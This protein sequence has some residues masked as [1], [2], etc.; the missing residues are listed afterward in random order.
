MV[1]I[2][3]NFGSLASS[4]LPPNLMSAT[5]RTAS[6][7]TMGCTAPRMP[8][9]PLFIMGSS[10]QS[11]LGGPM[12][13]APLSARRLIIPSG[14]NTQLIIPSGRNTQQACQIHLIGIASARIKIRMVN[15]AYSLGRQRLMGARAARRSGTDR[16]TGPECRS[17]TSS[18]NRL[19]PILI[20][21]TPKP[22][23][24]SKCPTQICFSSFLR[25]PN[26]RKRLG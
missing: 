12:P 11:T 8:M 17:E 6:A 26:W 5:Q 15:F 24:S 18:K 25:K 13:I 19:Q 16:R 2:Y 14:R 9:M 7:S 4:W 10:C 1:L 23:G 22:A 21:L 20:S 3:V